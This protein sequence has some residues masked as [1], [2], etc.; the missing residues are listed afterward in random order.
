VKTT[1]VRS[2]AALAAAAAFAGPIL[3]SLATTVPPVRRVAIGVEERE[4]GFPADLRGRWTVD[5]DGIF[6]LL[7]I[8][9]RTT[10]PRRLLGHQEIGLELLPYGGPL[11][12]EDASLSFDGTSCTYRTKPGFALGADGLLT[13]QRRPG[14]LRLDGAPP[15]GGM[16]LTLRLR[17]AGRAALRVAVR[18]DAPPGA[19]VAST[20]GIVNPPGLLLVRGTVGD[21]ATDRPGATRL[22]L[23]AY[24][25]NV[26]PSGTWIVLAVLAAGAGIFAAVQLAS[27]MALAT[28]LAAF[29]L[30]ATY[31]VLVPPFQAAD[32]PVHFMTLVGALRR[33][34]L[35]DEAAA[36]ARK[37]RFE[38]L[39]SA[40]RPFTP[41]DLDVP[42]QPWVGVSAPDTSRGAGVT[43]LWI[44]VKPLLPHASAPRVL[45][46]LRLFHSLLFAAAASL[47]VVIARR[48]TDARRPELL[49]I[50]LFLVPTLPYFGMHLSNYAPL[51]A[52]YVLFAA[53]AV[54]AFWDGAESYWAAP[55][56]GAA[57]T[58]GVALSRSAMPLG[59]LAAGI[60]AAR[61]C[62]G[63]SRGNW[64]HSVMYWGLLAATA[65]V[66]LSLMNL[67]YPEGPERALIRYAIA[68]GRLAWLL[69]NPWWL[70]IPAAAAAGLEIA[71]SPLARRLSAPSALRAS[72]VRVTA[73]AAAIALGAWIAVSPWLAHPVAIPLD[74]RAPITLSEYVTR[75]LPALVA[76][77][78]FGRPDVLTSVTF[79]GGFGWLEKLLPDGIVSALAGASGLA[80]VALLAWVGWRMSGRALAWIAWAAAGYV[81]AAGAYAYTARLIFTEVHGRYVLGLYLAALA[82]AWS[83]VARW[84]DEGRI[85]RPGLVTSVAAACVL[86]LHAW[87]LTYLLG[88][89]F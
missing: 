3:V 45:L 23:L 51:V 33:P 37:A 25:W 77:P 68:H 16:M 7:R 36:W 39:R 62:L 55:L 79:W 31:A 38:E 27:R 75:T 20:F 84:T 26:A 44:L 78:R 54:V 47:F 41:A 19:V 46:T 9:L 22:T 2:V 29:A 56:L 80:L 11:D 18:P 59:G 40:G 17:S 24:V 73:Y 12:L 14:C 48:L 60:A 52:L 82:I 65:I 86:A 8:G 89:Y 85:R 1:R 43:A 13:V 66:G 64:R 70:A 61:V 57:V 71:I 32:E 74:P 49:A 35:A 6:Y 83:G 72:I 87:T 88:R 67:A 50:P 34:H 21:L 10:D 76:W 4:A 58:I 28:F 69:H 30:S 42:G 81:V 63:D 5:P 15:T 53:S